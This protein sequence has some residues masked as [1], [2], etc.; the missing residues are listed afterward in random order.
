VALL[1]QCGIE[2]SM[3]RPGNPYDNAF[4]ESFMKT[5]KTEEVD[6]RRYASLEEASES[7][8]AFI[9]GFYNSERL[10]SALDYRSPEEFETNFRS[11]Q[12]SERG[13]FSNAHAREGVRL[14]PS[15]AL[16]SPAPNNKRSPDY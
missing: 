13:I 14:P 10:H 15:L 4:A 3:S 6:G 11:S 12:N 5:L 2:I 9:D 16:P 8:G 7:I 1:Q